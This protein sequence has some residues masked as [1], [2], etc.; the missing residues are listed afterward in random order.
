MGE[1]MMKRMKILLQMNTR[2]TPYLDVG[3]KALEQYCQGMD[4]L[5]DDNERFK[6]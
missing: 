6:H 2:G 5:L 4:L 1:D 3:N